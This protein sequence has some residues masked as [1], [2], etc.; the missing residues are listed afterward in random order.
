MLAVE[1]EGT[2]DLADA[3]G[4]YRRRAEVLAGDSPVPPAPEAVRA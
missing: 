2:D 1:H 4:R 3:L